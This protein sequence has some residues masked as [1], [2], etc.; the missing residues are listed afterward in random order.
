MLTAAAAVCRITLDEFKA[1]IAEE[2]SEEAGK[3]VNRKVHKATVTFI[4][5]IKTAHCCGCV[6]NEL[7]TLFGVY[8]EVVIVNEHVDK[9]MAA[10]HHQVAMV[11]LVE[12]VRVRKENFL[13]ENAGVKKNRTNIEASL[14]R[15]HAAIITI[16]E[17]ANMPA[18]FSAAKIL[19][20]LDHVTAGEGVAIRLA[21]P[22]PVPQPP[23]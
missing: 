8:E 3:K 20:E 4:E 22:D 13:K 11:E 19:D 1:A 5:K 18:D 12:A 7:K 10:A 15:V 6:N 21:K 14:V 2:K 23:A 16:V 9:Q 17:D